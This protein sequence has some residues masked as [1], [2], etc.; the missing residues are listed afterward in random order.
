MR[1]EN[2]YGDFVPSFD[3]CSITHAHLEEEKSIQIQVYNSSDI[4]IL[5][6]FSNF[7]RCRMV[8]RK[9]WTIFT[10]KKF[11]NG[12]RVFLFVSSW[13]RFGLC[14]KRRRRLFFI[15]NVELVNSMP[16]HLAVRSFLFSCFRIEIKWRNFDRNR[17]SS[18]FD[19]FQILSLN[20]IFDITF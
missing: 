8:R 20:Q 3:F 9:E 5:I 11:L 16:D 14:G 2:K 17:T 15:Y 18:L 7:H 13:T 6:E 1:R 19:F 4:R 12:F 10:A